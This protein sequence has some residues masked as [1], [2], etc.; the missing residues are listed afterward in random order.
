[1][2]ATG[3]LAKLYYSSDSGVTYTAFATIEDITGNKV[4]APKVKTTKLDSPAETSQPG[5]PDY[6]SF[7]LKIRFDKVISGTIL[8]W[9]NAKTLLYFKAQVNDNSPNTGTSEPCQG[10]VS[11]FDPFGQLVNNK[12]VISSITLTLTGAASWVPGS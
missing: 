12:E 7:Q 3:D 6:G 11:D 8:G 1:M 4:T 2:A 5:L 10:Y 9:M